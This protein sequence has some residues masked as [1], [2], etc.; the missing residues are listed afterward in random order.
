[1]ERRLESLDSIGFG[2][3]RGV[4]R[5]GRP[6]AEPGQHG[7]EHDR[8]EA[9]RGRDPPPANAIAVFFRDPR[10][11]GYALADTL[12]YPRRRILPGE[13]CVRSVERLETLLKRLTFPQQS[14]H[15]VRL[16]GRQLVEAVLLQDQVGNLE[17]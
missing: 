10:S 9:D 16:L 3:R 12:G 7:D 14:L 8:R 2:H 17:P 13:L 5:V 1:H 6:G 11:L 4:T 15:A